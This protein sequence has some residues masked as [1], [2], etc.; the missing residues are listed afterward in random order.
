MVRFE[1]VTDALRLV[2]GIEH[3]NLSGSPVSDADTAASCLDRSLVTFASTRRKA[4]A[5]EPRMKSPDWPLI[6]LEVAFIF[7]HYSTLSSSF[8]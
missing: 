4:T 1:N 3:L 5:V 8:R 6:E 2:L 7:H